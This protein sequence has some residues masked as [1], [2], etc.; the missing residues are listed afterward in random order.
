MTSNNHAL[1]SLNK[2]QKAAVLHTKG[3]LRI[4]A[5]AG[6]GKTR[7]LTQKIIYLIEKLKVA[8]YKIL[9]VT[10]TN[11]ATKE[12]S[13]RISTELG[14][15]KS[16]VKISTFHALCAYILR[17]DIEKIGYSK[18]FDILDV[19]DQKS[20]LETIYA[21]YEIS[22][23]EHS[24]SHLIQFIS[25]KKINLESPE[26]LMKEVDPDNEVELLF[27]NIYRD[28]LDTLKN[29]N[30]LDFDDL[31][32]LTRKLLTE[33]AEAQK[34]WSSKFDYI[35]V[36]EFQDTSQVQYDI[37]K[38][39]ANPKNNITVVGDPDQTIYSWR[40]AD[41]NIILNFDKDFPNT[42]TIYLEENYRSTPKIIEASNLLIKHNKN[43]LDKN[44]FTNNEN[45]D[46]IEF[47]HAF[48]PESEA[49]WVL[50]KINTLKKQKLQL[51][52]IAILFRSNYYSRNFEQI[53]IKEN[54][55]HVILGGQKFYERAEI[56]NIISF[57]KLINN[58]SE[59][60][61]K[62]IINVPSRKIGNSAIKKIQ[63]LAESKNMS[64]YDVLTDYFKNLAENKKDPNF[65]PLNIPMQ[66]QKNIVEFFNIVR[67][68]KKAL[69]K[70]PIHVVLK[71]FLNLIGYYSIFKENQKLLTNAVE[72]I[73]EL[74]GSIKTWQNKN[75]EGKLND[76]LEEIFLL[77]SSDWETT[78]NTYLTMMTVHMAK[79]L[80]FKHVFLVGMSEGNFPNNLALQNA[81]NIDEVIEEERRLAYVAITRAK[82]NLYIS[83]SQTSDLYQTTS[84]LKPPK[85][86]NPSRFLKEMGLKTNFGMK[87]FVLSEKN[88]VIKYEKDNSLLVVGDRIAHVTFGEGTILEDQDETIIVKFVNYDEPKL[89][90]KNHKSLQ[91]I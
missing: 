8:P 46:D 64:S 70:E 40:G 35:L 54:V 81:K 57:L 63:S 65:V 23:S 59:L 68:A 50:S 60:A 55:K 32:I 26:K 62:R 67:W 16:E 87:D 44:L 48:S 18:G 41:V 2:Q 10:F 37:V 58:G 90:L 3:P 20:I 49:K 12:M 66:A 47:F 76:Y 61:F 38:I 36:D 71:K 85:H 28:Y 74:I 72:N 88:G 77:T 56:K 89:L 84:F 29:L 51:K 43:R 83:N 14:D 7:V 11:K 86:A 15:L 1:N 17:Q 4:I 69:E 21:K 73:D 31:L 33:N 9:A 91:K 42:S 52:D 75:P 13:E 79:G 5:G 22:A 25:D 39:I 24:Y 82:E 19:I 53:F 34:Y 27:I 30:N 45:K 78:D 80:E 6:T